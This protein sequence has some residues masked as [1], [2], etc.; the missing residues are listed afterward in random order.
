MTHQSGCDQLDFD[1]DSTCHQP[2]GLP[3]D[4]GLRL[5]LDAEQS[6]LVEDLGVGPGA[7]PVDHASQVQLP[8]RSPPPRSWAA[9]LGLGSGFCSLPWMVIF[10]ARHD[11]IYSLSWISIWIST[12]SLR[13]AWSCA[14]PG[15]H[16]CPRHHANCSFCCASL[17]SIPV[18]SCPGGGD[19]PSVVVN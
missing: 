13:R 3:L 19:P 5:G 17:H 4:F 12:V 7:F 1:L 8:P 15:H 2:G 18:L 14:A 6:T 16:T 11:G 10:F 9:V